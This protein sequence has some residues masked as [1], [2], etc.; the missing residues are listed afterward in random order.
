MGVVSGKS[1]NAL[2]AKLYNEVKAVYDEKT[3]HIIQI[4][5]QQDC[6]VFHVPLDSPLSSYIWNPLAMNTFLPTII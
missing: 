1:Y 2:E 5:F 3:K 4:I 6:S